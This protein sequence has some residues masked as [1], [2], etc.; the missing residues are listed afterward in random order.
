MWIGKST[1]IA[2]RRVGGWW[3]VR[4]MNFTCSFLS[5]FLFSHLFSFSWEFLLSYRPRGVHKTCLLISGSQKPCARQV[6]LRPDSCRKCGIHGTVVCIR[7]VFACQMIPK[8]PILPSAWT[9]VHVGSQRAAPQM[10]SE[11][12]RQRPKQTKTFI[13]CNTRGSEY[14]ACEQ[15]S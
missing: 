10:N 9:H 8:R 4:N 1:C 15:T 7:I 3:H 6:S 2:R 11:I 13:L 14:N 5:C 12:R